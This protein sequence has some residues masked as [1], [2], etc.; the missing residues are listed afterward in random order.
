MNKGA[1]LNAHFLPQ[2]IICPLDRLRGRTALGFS[3]RTAQL[4]S[5]SAARV[6]V[7]ADIKQALVAHCHT[8]QTKF[9]QLLNSNAATELRTLYE[10]MEG[11]QKVYKSIALTP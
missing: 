7:R 9:T 8:W 3:N 5:N 1:Q 4:I 10:H 11:V 2:Q 6:Y